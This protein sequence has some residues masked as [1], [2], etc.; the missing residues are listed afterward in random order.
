MAEAIVATDNST[1]SKEFPNEEAAMDWIK[2]MLAVNPK[3][4]WTVQ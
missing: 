3:A 2:G 4:K 1:Y